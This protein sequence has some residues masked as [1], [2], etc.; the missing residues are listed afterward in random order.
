MKLLEL[1]SGTHSVGKLFEGDV[2]S[3]DIDGKYKPTHITDILKWDYKQYDK[4]AFDF[5]WA[6]PPCVYYSTLQFAWRGRKRADG[7]IFTKEKHEKLMEKADSWV[8]KTIEIINYFKPKFW[9]IENP[10]SGALKKREIMKGIPFVDVDYCRYCNWGYRKPTR[11]WTNKK[12]IG[13]RCD[14][15]NNC[16]NMVKW[17]DKPLKYIRKRPL[18][19]PRSPDRLFHRVDASKELSRDERYRVPPNLLRELLK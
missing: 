6:S 9:F 16:G 4:D 14:M 19:N 5:I 8:Q 11:I 2:V 10:E 1:F 3:V 13:K 17:K 18:K 7:E 15:K 12:I